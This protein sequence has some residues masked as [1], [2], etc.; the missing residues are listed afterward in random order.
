[1]ELGEAGS[2]QQHRL[3]GCEEAVIAVTAVL[4]FPSDTLVTG[5]GLVRGRRQFMVKS[6]YRFEQVQ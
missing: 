5:M 4:N 2:Y 1:M 6:H 3:R